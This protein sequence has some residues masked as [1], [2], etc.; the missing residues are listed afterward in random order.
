MIRIFL[1]GFML[2]MGEVCGIGFDELSLLP[3]G[4]TTAVEIRGFLYRQD[5][6]DFYLSP[7]PNLKSCCVGSVAKKSSQIRVEG[8]GVMPPEG[9]SSLVAGDLTVGIDGYRLKNARVVEETTHTLA[10]IAAIV[11]CFVGIIA[12]LLVRPAR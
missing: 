3:A 11:F 2:V 7:E 9:F 8:I 6:G 4:E 10:A 12:Y 1:I 5:N